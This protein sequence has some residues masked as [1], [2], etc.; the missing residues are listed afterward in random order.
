MNITVNCI[1]RKLNTKKFPICVKEKVILVVDNVFFI[2]ELFII[3]GFSELLGV[4][5]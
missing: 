1:K 5:T 4:F 2:M 3:G